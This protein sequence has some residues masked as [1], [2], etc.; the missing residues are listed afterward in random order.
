MA[1]SNLS[2]YGGAFFT[3]VIAGIV[4]EKMGYKWTFWFIAIFSGVLLPAVVL[5]VPETAY[6]RPAHLNTDVYTP[7]DYMNPSS[8]SLDSAKGCDDSD[9]VRVLEKE[10]WGKSLRLFNGRK[11]NEPFWKLFICPLPLLVHPAILWGM[12]TQG[13]L[14]AWTVMIGVDVAFLYACEKPLGLGIYWVSHD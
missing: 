6:N 8:T 11:S 3:P 13:T 14:I 12:L 1:F 7:D 5:F 2:L 4:T 10:S 9:G